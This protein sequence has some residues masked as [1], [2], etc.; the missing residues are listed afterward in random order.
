[1][2]AATRPTAAARR[3]PDLLLALGVLVIVASLLLSIRPA[4]AASTILVADSPSALSIAVSQ[5]TVDD[6]SAEAVIVMGESADADLWGVPA[7]L[8]AT[9]GPASILLTSPSGPSPE[10]LAELDRASAPGAVLYVV[11]LPEV[12]TALSARGHVVIP[13]SGA[14]AAATS[15]A[16]ADQTWGAPAGTTQRLVVVAAAPGGHL[17]AAAANVHGANLGIPVLALGQ[18]QTTDVSPTVLRELR[19][20]ADPALVADDAVGSASAPTVTR[21]FSADVADVAASLDDL[22][23]AEPGDGDLRDRAGRT[24][25]A[26]E[27]DESHPAPAVLAAVV[28]AR[29]ALDGYDARLEFVADPSAAAALDPG[30][31]VTFVGLGAAEPAPEPAPLPATGGGIAIGAMVTA[32]GWT[33]RRRRL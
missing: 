10:V 15:L 33:L 25:V 24:A 18:G 13:I 12:A 11:N 6:G 28:A 4:G 20:V 5:A 17:L 19:L 22:V 8:A 3:L 29:D 16:L 23:L 27:A 1:M 9:P 14:D 32:L 26:I 21:V 2:S 30:N 7:A 31:G